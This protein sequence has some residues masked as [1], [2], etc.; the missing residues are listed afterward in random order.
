MPKFFICYRRED[1]EYPA[2]WIS[3][4][5]ISQYGPDSVVFDVDTIPPGADYRGY[6]RNQVGKCDALL[7]IIGDR[8]LEILRDRSE[9]P[10]DFVRIEI[11][12]AMEKQIPV[13]PVLVGR[14]QV[15]SEDELP[16]EL[17]QRSEERL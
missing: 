11:L 4:E 10:N 13:V 6:L 9:D 17:G 2:Q 7:A 3:Q 14:A 12:A 16:S 5:L 15:P 8:W 1:S